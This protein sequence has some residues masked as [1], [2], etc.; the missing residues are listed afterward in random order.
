MIALF[1]LTIFMGVKFYYQNVLIDR[2]ILSLSG[3]HAL[4]ERG[5]HTNAFRV[6]RREKEKGARVA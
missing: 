1:W 4:D 6:K 2:R 3:A 5:P